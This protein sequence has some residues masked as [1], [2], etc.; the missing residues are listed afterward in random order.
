MV[1]EFYRIPLVEVMQVQLMSLLQEI[2]LLMAK[3]QVVFEVALI[4]KLMKVQ[5]VIL[6][7]SIFLLTIST[8]PME[9]E[10]LL[11]HSVKVMQG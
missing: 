2:L 4:V 5:K 6:E 11:I 7:E 8:L 10:L 9:V 3:A 1:V